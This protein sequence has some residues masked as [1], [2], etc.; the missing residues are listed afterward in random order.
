MNSL[1]A[2]LVTLSELYATY[3][4]VSLW[5]IG[6]LAANRGSFFVDL[7]SG[8]R[9]CQTN[10]YTRVLQYFSDHWPLDLP[11]PVDIPRPD[12]SPESPAVL[13]LIER[14][15]ARGNL[16]NSPVPSEIDPLALNARGELANPVAITPQV[17]G[18][19]DNPAYRTAVRDSVYQVVRDY[20][21]AGP[22]AGR[23][24][25]AGSRAHKI[26]DLMV[27]A[28]DV[29]FAQRAA[30]IRRLEIPS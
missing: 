20:A 1:T 13:A 2:S 6:H 19:M 29:R 16:N 25:R 8:R 4:D 5:R 26:L 11:W 9:Y 18:G 15:Q 27:E 7:K 24:P 21:D 12:P 28:G 22:R 30:L 10:T 23:W 3:R 17:S 14:Q